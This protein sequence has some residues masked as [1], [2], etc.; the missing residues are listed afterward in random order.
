MD[1]SGVNQLHKELESFSKENGIQGKGPLSVVLILSRRAR[2]MNKPLEPEG[3]LTPRGGQVAG[4]SGQNVQEILADHGISRV[5]SEEGGRTSRGSMERMRR[6]VS[7]LNHL[8]KSKLLDFEAIE[9]WW[10]ERIR[11]HFASQPL[12]LKLDASKSLR[13]IVAELIEAAFER[14]RE[15]RG[16]MVAGAVMQHLV[17]A[18]LEVALP[19]QPITH[20]GFS[21]ADAPGKRKGDFVVNDTA[22]HVTTAPSEALIR[23]CDMNLSENLRPLI[24]TTESG[25]GG[26]K[27]LAKNSQIA[28]RV[29]ILDIEQFIATNI[30]EWSAFEHGRRPTSI[31]ELIDTYNRVIESCETDHSLKIELG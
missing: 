13:N 28:G 27:A 16:T 1:P 17:G 18:K 14:Q 7:L 23:K 2:S 21:V 15:C 26:A 4:L 31:I 30:Y 22:I 25:T 20:E 9:E 19:D 5:L 24:I 10:I 29:D 12:R 6:Y 3:F 8:N 11:E